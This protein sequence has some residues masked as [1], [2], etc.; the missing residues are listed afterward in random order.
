MARP[1][2]LLQP[3]GH[4]TDG[5][6]EYDGFSRVSRQQG[7]VVRQEETPTMTVDRIVSQFSQNRLNGEP[8]PD[9][10]K[11]LLANRDEFLEQTEIELNGKKGWAPWLDTSYLSAE[12]RANPDIAANVQAIAEVCGLIA[13]IGADEE[14][15]YFGYWRGP[16][17]RPIAKSPLV[18]LDNEG[19]F[20]L[21]AGCTFAEAILVSQTYDAEQ[22]TEL[23]DWFR[24]LGI[25]I[26]WESQEAA[27][28]PKEKDRPDDL[29]KDLYYRLLGKKPPR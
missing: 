11:T 12:E 17:N 3:T 10:V 6:S 26:E 7:Q 27:T 19:Q 4:A 13:F 9:D 15:N 2:N 8:V 22:F 23:R 29:H 16:K 1:N 14:G 24:S 18:R 21:L 28:Y 20:E 5:H 25:S